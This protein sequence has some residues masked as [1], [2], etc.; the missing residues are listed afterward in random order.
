MDRRRFLLNASGTVAGGLLVPRLGV[1]TT[2]ADRCRGTIAASALDTLPG[3]RPLMRRSFRPPNFETPVELFSEPYTPNDAFY[4]RW[5]RAVPE[6]K[7]ADWRLR[8]AGPGG[9]GRASSATTNCAASSAR[10]RSPPSTS[11]RAIAVACS[12]R[13]SLACS[14]AMAPWATRPGAAC[15]SRT[16]SRTPAWRRARS[17]SSLMVRMHL[18]SRDRISSR[19]CRCGRPRPGHATASR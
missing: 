11:A 1:W 4:V 14:G 19:A 2:A 6:V 17:R 8:V 9:N 13:T 16:S 3:K 18:R 12:R 5:H 7:L 10:R 15:G